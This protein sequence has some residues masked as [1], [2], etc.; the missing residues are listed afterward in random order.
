MPTVKILEADLAKLALSKAGTS[1]IKL[2]PI[3]VIVNIEVD[4]KL[5]KALDEDP[6]LHQQ[7]ADKAKKK[8]DVFAVELG[9]LIK[10]TA[11]KIA[12]Q[13]GDKEVFED[14]AEKEFER[15]AK[16]A[17]K[18]LPLEVMKTWEKLKARKAEYKAYKIKAGIKIATGA[19]SLTA[20]V[21]VAATAP[22]TGAGAVLGVAGMLK[23]VSNI[24]QEIVKLSK[25][26]PKVM[27]ELDTMLTKVANRYKDATNS[28]KIGA[29]E[30]GAAVLAQLT[31]F[32]K[33]SIAKC[34][35]W[36]DLLKNKLNGVEV[37]AH[38]I[39]KGLAKMLA[40][41]QKAQ[42]ELP[43]YLDKIKP[44]IPSAEVVKIMGAAGKVEKKIMGL[45]SKIQEMIGKCQKTALEAKLGRDSH[46]IL[47]AKVEA[48]KEKVPNWS[49]VL[50]KATPLLE[51]ATC[52]EWGDVAQTAVNLAADAV[53]ETQAFDKLVEKIA[54]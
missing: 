32:K 20:S 47:H 52:L 46:K 36:D 21:A 29:E 26:M 51:F 17:E 44:N 3:P 7:M 16:E 37:N 8:L 5:D 13:P 54:A 39:A 14:K 4:A 38:N 45:F 33:D 53:Q 10:E 40:D 25:D 31:T 23:T 28:G 30:L 43:K 24:A 9:G 2:K 22:F 42:A 1:V 15:V 50:Q 48:L 34:G 19:V 11:E 12:K 27:T 6:L 41:M 18:Q 35:E 49:M